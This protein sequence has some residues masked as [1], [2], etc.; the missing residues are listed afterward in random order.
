MIVDRVRIDWAQGAGALL[1]CT[2]LNAVKAVFAPHGSQLASIASA[3]LLRF[4]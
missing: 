2:F 1:L 4:Q 3:F